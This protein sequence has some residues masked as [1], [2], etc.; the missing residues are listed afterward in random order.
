MWNRVEEL[1]GRAPSVQALGTHRLHLIAARVWSSRG[2]PVQAALQAEERRAAII[3][4]AARP[5]L[6][7][8]RAAYGGKLMLMKGAEVAAHYRHRSDRFFC[9]LDLLADDPSAAQRALIKAGFVQCGDP[10]AYER[11]QHLCPL[12]WPGVPLFVELHR[13]PNSPAWLPRTAAEEI[14]GLAVP[15]ALEI[16]GLLAPDPPAHALLL[17]AH[18]WAQEPLARLADLIDVAAVLGNGGRASA[19]D[20]ARRWGWE[21]MWQVAVRAGDAVLRDGAW[22][23][24]LSVWARHLTAARDRTVLESH[25]ARIA[26]PASA[27]PVSHSPA[28]LANTIRLAAARHDGEPWSDKLRRSGLAVTH[29]FMARSAHEH[30]IAPRRLR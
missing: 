7:R 8:A 21:R 6:E 4:M 24:S 10:A 15:S 2:W 26:G 25:I 28:A 12:V 20:L 27:L 23:T 14:L 3:T 1:V 16:D 22:P 19:D 5:L 11:A 13:R 18:S 29:A 9:D 17:V 30:T